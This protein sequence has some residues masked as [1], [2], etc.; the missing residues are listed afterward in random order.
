MAK[1]KAKTVSWQRA[2]FIAACKELKPFSD[3]WHDADK[4]DAMDVADVMQ[5]IIRRHGRPGYVAANAVASAW[6][7]L[8]TDEDIRSSVDT[9]SEDSV[10]SEYYMP[11]WWLGGFHMMDRQKP[12]ASRRKK[13]AAKKRRS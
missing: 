9:V 11:F 4:I 1:K 6:A 7:W 10:A 12:L 13:R 2:V 3:K 5:D 8:M